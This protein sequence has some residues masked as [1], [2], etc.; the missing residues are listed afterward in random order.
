VNARWGCLIVS[1]LLAAFF[2]L[3]IIGTR[4]TGVPY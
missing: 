3:A 2:L 4:L 1:L